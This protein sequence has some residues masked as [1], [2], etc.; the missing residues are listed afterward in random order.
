MIILIKK[1]ADEAQ[2][3]NL[4][5]LLKSRNIEPHVSKGSMQTLIGCVGDVAHL[6]PSLIEALDVV[7]SVQRIQ[8][9]YKAANRRFHPDDTAVDCAGVKI[10]AGNFGVIAG[11]CSVESEEQLVGIAK[12][13][14]AAGAAMLRGGAFKPR[15]S[16]YAFQGLGAEGLRILSVAKRETGLPI[17]TELMDFKDIELFNDVDVIQIG[18]R[19]MQNFNLLK[20]VGSYTKKPVLLKRGMS[21]TIQELLMSAE[22][23]MASGNPN[24]ILCE[25]GIRTFETSLRNTLDLGVV[26]LLHRLSHLPVVV[27]PSHAT[28]YSYM[29]DPVA[30]AAAAIGA[31]GLIVEVHNDPPHALCDGVQSQT[32]E[33]FAKTMARIAKVR[34]AIA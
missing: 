4:K 11:P 28:G 6:D 13:V 9:P 27:D 26:P 19:N 5:S 18:A 12:S 29:V 15:T 7:E 2:V 23:I 34:G 17:V 16:P 24:V 8:E 22:Y 21:A 31:D 30:V 20:E 25:R 32:P 33:M 3:E 1:G 14:K 10:G